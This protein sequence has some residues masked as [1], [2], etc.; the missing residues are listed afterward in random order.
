MSVQVVTL[1]AR[2]PRVLKTRACPH[3]MRNNAPRNGCRTPSPRSSPLLVQ[4][5]PKHMA[6][7][8]LRSSEQP[9]WKGRAVQLA[10]WQFTYSFRARSEGPETHGALRLEVFRAA[11]VE[12]SSSAVGRMA[13]CKIPP[14]LLVWPQKQYGTLRLEVFR[15]AGG[16]R[17][18]G[19]AV[20]AWQFAKKL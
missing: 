11:G 8:D 12:R 15:V 13:N 9:V 7:L 1:S 16:E 2:L 18:S 10:E 19:A 14:C 3:I 4:R 20:A 6:P 17:P 5:A